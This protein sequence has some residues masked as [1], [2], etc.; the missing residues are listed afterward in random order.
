MTDQERAERLA[1]LKVRAGATE[2]ESPAP[3]SEPAAAA[4]RV[5]VARA[6][7]PH[8]AGGARWV[9][10]GVSAAATVGMIGAM[11]ASTVA[12]TNAA[13]PETVTVVV[14]PAPSGQ[15]P[16]SVVPGSELAMSSSADTAP[17]TP[18]YAVVAAG[19][20]AATDSGGS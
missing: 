19:A 20:P 10:A 4:R 1:A 6:K 15:V 5:P 18:S 3:G 8:A 14:Q 11:T 17:A 12:A 9:V 13:G 7:R 16:G 2:G